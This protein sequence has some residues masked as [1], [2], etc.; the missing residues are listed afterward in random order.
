MR[1]PLLAGLLF[2]LVT[3]VVAEHKHRLSFCLPEGALFKRVEKLLHRSAWRTERMRGHPAAAE[4]SC[5]E[6]SRT[7]FSSEPRNRSLS[8]WRLITHPNPNMYPETYEEAKCLCSGCIINGKENTD[9]NSVP[10]ERSMMFLKKV[11]CKADPQK[12][13]L[14]IE[15]RK[16]PVA[17]TCVVPRQ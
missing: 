16:I 3:D 1:F 13:S 10:V 17:C 9:Y 11:A 14:I 8:P 7:Q 4:L 2:V 12:Y 5:S 6:F 15:H